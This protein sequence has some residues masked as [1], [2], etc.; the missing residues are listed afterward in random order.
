MLSL[1]LVREGTSDD[2]L[3][4]PLQKLVASLSQLPALATSRTY[5]G[6]VADKIADVMSEPE[7]PDILFV[8]RDSDAREIGPRLE[9]IRGAVSA[10]SPP[11]PCV[12]VVPV[13]ATEAWLLV[14]ETAIRNVV[15]RPR[16]R[17][18][19][20]LPALRAI[21][22]QHAPKAVL[23]EA[24][25]RASESTGRRREEVVKRFPH[26]RRRLLERLDVYGDVTRL[27]SWQRLERSVLEALDRR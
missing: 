7:R 22:N 15:G 11:F 25:L 6:A 16:G 27:A 21:E 23:R 26:H 18:P 10:A 8:H 24:L 5:G 13:Q 2:G 12:P 20:G 17:E 1:V 9:E 4:L 14:S 19:L 3:L